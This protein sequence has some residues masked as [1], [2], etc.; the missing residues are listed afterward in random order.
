MSAAFPDPPRLE[1]LTD[2]R[3]WR[4]LQDFHFRGK[5]RSVTVPAGFVTDFASTPRWA[6]WLLPPWGKYGRAALVHDFCYS[7]Q[8]TTKAEA[9]AVFLEGMR[10]SGVGRLRARVMFLAVALFGGAAWRGHQKGRK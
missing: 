6:W 5:D 2:G 7:A 10:L 8:F 9:D 3:R 1:A 4:V